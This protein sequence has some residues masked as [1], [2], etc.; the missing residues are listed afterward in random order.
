[1]NYLFDPAIH[2]WLL[3]KKGTTLLNGINLSMSTNNIIS[4]KWSSRAHLSCDAMAALRRFRTQPRFRRRRDLAWQTD[5]TAAH[6]WLVSVVPRDF[7]RWAFRLARLIQRAV[8]GAPRWLGLPTALK[9]NNIDIVFVS[10][11]SECSG[12]GHHDFVSY[13][14]NIFTLWWSN[15][16]II[17]I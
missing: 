4:G 15:I 10:T 14:V 1:M 5:S 16:A 12:R 13:Q 17:L 3:N 8:A 9:N 11:C 7:T 6:V 2:F